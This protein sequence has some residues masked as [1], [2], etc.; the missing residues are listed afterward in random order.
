MTHTVETDSSPT[1]AEP[2]RWRWVALF[3]VLAAEVMDLMDAMITIIAAPSVQ[4]ELGGSSSMIQWLSAGYTLAM[5][6]GL[7]TGGRLGDLYGRRRMFVVGAFGFT[8]FSLLCGLATSP[9]MLIGARVLQGLA[10]AVMVPQGLGIIKEVFPP[11]ELAAAFGAFGPVMALS[12]VGVPSS[13][14]GSSTATS[15]APDGA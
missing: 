11:K 5:A 7:V 15:S 6:I 1:G 10:G 8:L 3:V 12:T 9:E 14:A 2:Y 13:R 4:K